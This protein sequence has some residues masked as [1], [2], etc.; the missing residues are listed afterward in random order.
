MGA[1]AVGMSTAKEAEAGVSLGLTVAAISCITNKAAGLGDGPLD[2]KEVL[3]TAA[4]PAD[5]LA[6]L[7]AGL[8]GA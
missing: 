4:A 6:D 2:H 3:Q 8:F 5:R 7:L 1:D